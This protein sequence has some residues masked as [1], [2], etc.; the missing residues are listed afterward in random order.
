MTGMP[1][2]RQHALGQ[3]TAR[4]GASEYG[5]RGLLHDLGHQLMTLSLLA[6]SLQADGE[7]PAAARRRSQLMAQETVRALDMISET[8]SAGC[9]QHQ[10]ATDLVDLRELAGQVAQLTDLAYETT[11]RLAPGQ[12]AFLR[13]E[14]MLV[15]RV[16]CNIVDNAVRAAGPGGE[17]RI[18]IS[19]GNGTIVEVTDD[20]AG[21]GC[22][23]SG[24]SGPA[25]LGL[26]VVRQLLASCGGQLDI[27]A[28]PGGGT[29]VRATFG[30][31]C[32]RMVLPRRRRSWA[33]IA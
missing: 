1:P 12:A 7:L 15:W 33:A 2:D 10:P 20:G 24:P 13:V 6:D 17:V 8:G 27:S 21:F 5:L 25:G 29:S 22:G 32:D 3:L 28:G 23:P 30:S 9:H 18:S 11:V 19:R 26:T 14:P 31:R 16:L 4:D